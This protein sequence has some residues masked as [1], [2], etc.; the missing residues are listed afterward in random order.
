MKR[1][2]VLEGGAMRGMFTAGVTDVM[3]ENGITFDGIVGVSAGAAFGVNYKSG[4]IGRAI[5]YNERF[6]NDKRYC[7]IRNL[8]R[9]GNLYSKDFCYG[10]VPLVHDPFDFDAFEADPTEFH[11][12]CTD[13]ETGKPVYRNCPISNAESMQWF[14]ASASMPLVSRV[15]EVGGYRLLD[16]GVSDSIP[17]R[18][19]ES[20][21]YG[22]N[23]VIL[24]Q[25][26][27]YVKKPNKALPL[28]RL[29]LRKYPALL[30][31]IADRHH[32]YNRQVAHAESRAADG[33]AL[34]LRPEAPLD[35]SHT[36]HDPEKLRAAYR[37][38]QEVARKNLNR[39]HAFLTD[40]E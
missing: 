1:G 31:A 21:G 15:V 14:R 24:T 35:M 11:I 9:D 30:A 37:H 26:Q 27:G 5:R 4:Q 19:F 7:S 3:M 23:L 8:F 20:I 16:G 29:V 36:E 22:R 6:C 40:K 32:V 34:I 18:F 2:L 12:V 28:M 17:L 38:G 13:V 25:P 10:E 39:I 33:A